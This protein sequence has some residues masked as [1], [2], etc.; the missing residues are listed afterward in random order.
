M[1]SIMATDVLMKATSKPDTIYF[2]DRH[3]QDNRNCRQ[4]PEDMDTPRIF[5]IATIE[6]SEIADALAATY[7][8]FKHFDQVYF[9]T[10]L[11]R[12]KMVGEINF[13]VLINP[14]LFYKFWVQEVI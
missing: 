6:K 1:R 9:A 14:K 11:S 8:V 5:I 2:Q 13:I 7:I 10:L 4:R 12:V 3:S